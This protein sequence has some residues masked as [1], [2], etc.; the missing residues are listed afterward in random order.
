L[1]DPLH[2]H[3]QIAQAWWSSAQRDGWASCPLTENGFVRILSSPGYAQ[4]FAIA[5]AVLALK[6][7]IARSDHAFW[8]D[9]LSIADEKVVNHGRILGPKQITDVYLLALAVTNGGRLV[10]LD[11][12]IALATVLR[13]EPHHLLVL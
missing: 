10:S 5:D 1:F 2:V 7:Q 8:P 3:H 11:R 9:D 13:A 12:S 4:R 6:R